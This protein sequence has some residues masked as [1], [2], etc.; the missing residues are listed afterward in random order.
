[1]SNPHGILRQNEI[2]FWRENVLKQKG[3]M[4]RVMVNPY[5]DTDTGFDQ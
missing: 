1:M 2:Y 3:T 5:L 4:T